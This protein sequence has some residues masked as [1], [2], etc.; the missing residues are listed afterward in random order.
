[1]K[2]T[3]RGKARIKTLALP[4]RV[5]NFL[6]CHRSLI[7]ATL[8]RYMYFDD[9]LALSLHYSMTTDDR[10]I[11]YYYCC[12]SGLGES[13]GFLQIRTRELIDVVGQIETRPS[14]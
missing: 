10:I 12:E 5:S 14:S 13:F 9:Q 6:P 2:T 3:E 4:I 1:M 11:L 8:V 7:N